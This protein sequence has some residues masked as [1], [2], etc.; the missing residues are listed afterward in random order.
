MNA[1]IQKML[2]LQALQKSIY[3]IAISCLSTV[4][5]NH[6]INFLQQFKTTE[7]TGNPGQSRFLRRVNSE[8]E[9]DEDMVDMTS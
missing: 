4:A 9:N 8:S 6:T 5:V 7:I 3:G 2:D 1:Q